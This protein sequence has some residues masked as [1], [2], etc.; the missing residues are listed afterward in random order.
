M[1]L[2]H[3]TE[4]FPAPDTEAKVNAKVTGG[5]TGPPPR[6]ASLPISFLEP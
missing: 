5:E 2:L 1:F 3:D 4:L 6:Y